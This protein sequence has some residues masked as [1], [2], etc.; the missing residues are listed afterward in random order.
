[1]KPAPSTGQNTCTC[2]HKNRVRIKLE[3]VWSLKWIALKVQ[4]RLW[5]EFRL[6]AR[7]RTWKYLEGIWWFCHTIVWLL[8]A[9]PAI[10]FLRCCQATSFSVSA[11][12][13]K[14]HDQQDNKLWLKHHSLRHTSPCTQQQTAHLASL[15][16]NRTLRI[17]S[18]AP[19]SPGQPN[20]WLQ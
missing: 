18:T 15:S 17:A 1:M 12:W 16:Q 11:T 4:Y 2:F 10:D 19:E 8:V 13:S 6:H 20:N 7:A 14:Y 3:Q 5:H 9:V